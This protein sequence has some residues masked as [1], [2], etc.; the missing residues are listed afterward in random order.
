MRGVR[1]GRERPEVKR[2][3]INKQVGGEVCE[4]G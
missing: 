3:L 2:E 1:V 4:R